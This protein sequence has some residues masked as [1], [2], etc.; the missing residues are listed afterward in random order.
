[1]NAPAAAALHHDWRAGESARAA[2]IAEVDIHIDNLKACLH[3]L[4]AAGISVIDADLRRGRFKPRVT[5]APSPYLHTLFKSDAASAGQHWDIVA[6]RTVLDF[7][8]V[9]YECEIR[10]MEVP[11]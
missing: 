2:A 11:Q 4:I 8:A 10:W 1:M 5:V 9:R 6:G 3:W 7:V